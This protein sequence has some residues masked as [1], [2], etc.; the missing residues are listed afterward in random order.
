[1]R[2]LGFSRRLG[3]IFAVL[4]S[5]L[6]LLSLS[7]YFFN[8]LLTLLVCFFIIFELVRGIKLN[9]V[10]LRSILVVLIVLVTLWAGYWVSPSF[11]FWLTSSARQSVVDRMISDNVTPTR[12]EQEV[13]LK[14]SP[15]EKL[16]LGK[17]TAYINQDSHSVYFNYYKRGASLAH[18]A[19]F[20]IYTSDPTTIDP[21]YIQLK[22]LR[23][24]WFFLLR[25]YAD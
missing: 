6:F 7:S 11:N 8:Q 18:Q 5:L 16:L 23:N 9:R 4:F 13:V 19:A 14:N 21:R 10:S 3:I 24:N 17:A 2:I 20:F 25:G 12:L 15:I 22:Q 1:M